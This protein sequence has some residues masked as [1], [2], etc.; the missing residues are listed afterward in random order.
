MSFSYKP[1]W[2]LLERKNISKMQFA[3][4]IDVSNTTL[5]K[6]S[7]NEPVNLNIIDKICNLLNCRIENVVQHIPDVVLKPLQTEKPLELG[8]IIFV[9]ENIHE[10]QPLKTNY[11]VIAAQSLESMGIGSSYVYSVVPIFPLPESMLSK[12]FRDVVIN[13]EV[14]DGWIDF[15]Q[16][17]ILPYNLSISLV[18][19]MPAWIT[20]Q[21]DEFV[22]S[23]GKML[24]TLH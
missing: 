15:A 23:I 24:Q 20:K 5:A 22:H 18:G 16:Y 2:N 19:K 9:S 11:Y 14:V 10:G 12:P 21:I 7:K 6:L 4:K 1:L 8:T 13:G 3:A 17:S